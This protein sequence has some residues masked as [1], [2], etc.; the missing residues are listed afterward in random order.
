MGDAVDSQRSTASASAVAPGSSAEAAGDGVREGQSG[1]TVPGSRD[2]AP[3]AAGSEASPAVV[4]RAEPTGNVAGTPDPDGFT[5]SPPSASPTDLPTSQLEPTVGSEPSRPGGDLLAALP[6]SLA[7]LHFAPGIPASELFGAGR[8]GW[9]VELAYAADGGAEA[10]AGRL[11]RLR[12]LGYEPILR[13]DYDRRQNIPPAG[14]A[15]ALATYRDFATRVID[16]GAGRLRFVVIG[17]EPNIDE[18]GAGPARNTE[19]LAGRDGC[20]PAAYAAVYRELRGALRARGAFAL[21]AGV[22]PGGDN[23]PARWMG[24]PEYLAAVLAELRPG[25]V[26]GIALHA[27]GLEA[28]PVPGLP[29]EPLAYFQALVR[30]QLVAVDGA[31]HGA[32]PL[33]LTEM[34]QYTAPEPAFVH[35]AYGW[36]DGLNA[37]RRGD[38]LA[39]V[40]FVYEGGGAWNEVALTRSP[41]VLAAFREVAAR[42]P[43]GR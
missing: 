35:A 27:Y 20:Q 18:V 33:F 16:A 2:R 42:Y 19:C 17:N 43:A 21:V 32:T 11:S 13:L 4:T 23:H 5:S 29:P 38:I 1:T 37:A 39:A 10:V 3:G 34:N 41:D 7:G 40:W 14:D 8:R 6:D 9:A 24:G 31:G 36:L 22:S 12:D 30:R 25:Q 28:E 26:D 15:A